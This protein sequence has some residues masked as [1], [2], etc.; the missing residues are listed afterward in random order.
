MRLRNSLLLLAMVNLTGCVVADMDSSNYEYVPY[1]KTIQKQD[2]LGH[3]DTAQRKQ[4][5]WA[6]GL[7]KK[8]DPETGPFNRN[9]L[10][11]GETLA[12]HQ[13]RI[14]QLERCMESK[15]YVLLDFDKCGP[16]KAPTGMCN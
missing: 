1:V 11:N 6:C 2:R 4:D 10:E 7:S 5:L 3:T 9:Q 13:K 14:G 12:Q 8:V 15:G 16:L